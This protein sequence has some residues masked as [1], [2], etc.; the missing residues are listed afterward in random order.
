MLTKKKYWKLFLFCLCVVCMYLGEKM[1]QVTNKK[2]AMK[3]RETFK[4]FI[5]NVMRST[6]ID[7]TIPELEL[8]IKH[9]SHGMEV[10]NV[11][12][13]GNVI[14]A[15]V[16]QDLYTMSSR[17]SSAAPSPLSSPRRRKSL[18]L[19][20]HR[21]SFDASKYAPFRQTTASLGKSSRLAAPPIQSPKAGPKGSPLEP[22]PIPF[23]WKRGLECAPDNVT[24]PEPHI[25][26]AKGMGLLVAA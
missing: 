14:G 9:S 10:P 19:N 5:N 18:E 8:D 7:I 15:S 26:R 11:I 12:V 25:A 3:Q 20:D 2:D 1:L 24:Y 17:P 22:A 21:G 6:V 13:Q 16:T 4:T 23:K